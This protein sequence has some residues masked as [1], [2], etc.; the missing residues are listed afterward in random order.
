MVGESKAE[1]IS[2]PDRLG[3]F[4]DEINSWFHTHGRHYPWRDTGNP[5]FILIAER[6]LH[7][8]RSDQV[9]DT[10]CRFLDSYPTIQSL[11]AAAPEDVAAML[12]TLGLTWRLETIVPMAKLIVQLFGGHIP[13]SREQLLRLPGVGPYTA[14]AVL[15]FAFNLPVAVVD[16]NT[17]RVAGRYL[18]GEEWKGDN[19]KRG[20]VRSAVSSLI[21][22]D[23]PS[24]S[25]YA[26][27]DLGALVC[28]AR[29][30]LCQSC[31]V[32]AM[33]MQAQSQ[34]AST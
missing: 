31:P 11:A 1:V 33:C 17:V 24:I 32:S 9:V 29:R 3:Y 10:Y 18:A 15:A 26:I 2:H 21:D 20:S 28:Q 13:R 27:L 12:A 5:Y 30:R 14:D 4:R 34:L 6:M 8:T 7:R 19:R 23:N 22:V 16:T 25:N